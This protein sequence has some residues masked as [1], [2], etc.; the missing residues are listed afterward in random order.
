MKSSYNDD[1]PALQPSDHPRL[2]LINL[3][4]TGQNFQRWSKSVRIALRTKGKLD[5]LDES[6]AKPAENSSQFNQWIRCDSMD[7]SWPLNSMMPELAEAFLYVDSSRELWLKLTETFGDSNGPLLYQLEK[8]ISELYQGNDSVAV[9]YTKLKK[10]W[11]DL[12]DFS[13][14]PEC[15]CATTCEAM[16]KILTNEQRQKLMHFLMHLNDEYESV[17]GKILLLDPLPN[18]NKAYAMIQRVEKQKQVTGGVGM[19]REMATNVSKSNNAGNVNSGQPSTASL[20]ILDEEGGMPR[21]KKNSQ[22][23]QSL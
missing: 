5:S 13:E 15:K 14:V 18:V 4:L 12:S 1:T 19:I 16:K 20:G 21:I 17:R 10:L 8:E 23:L 7:L 11:E 3:K 9:Y 22:V 2:Q 6:C